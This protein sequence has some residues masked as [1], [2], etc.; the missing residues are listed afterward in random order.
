MLVCILD[1]SSV[2]GPS[3]LYL[4]NPDS[5]IPILVN[6]EIQTKPT[7]V[8]YT[9]IQRRINGNEDFNKNWDEYAHGFGNP[10]GMEFFF[11]ARFIH[12]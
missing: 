4:T 6:C 3:G 5:E 7:K 9:I 8:A 10:T 12:L 2:N 11:F 1:C